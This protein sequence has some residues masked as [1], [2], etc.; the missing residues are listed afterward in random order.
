MP[1]TLP[2]AEFRRQN[3]LHDANRRELVSSGDLP[4]FGQSRST[5]APLTFDALEAVFVEYGEK[6]VRG[7]A[8][9]LDKA[10]ANASGA[11]TSSI[12]FEFNKLGQSYETQIFMSDYLKF[13]DLG[14]QGVG[15]SSKNN[16]SPFKFKFVN[17][18][19]SHVD[20]LEKWVKEKNIR[21]VVT[22]PKGLVARDLSPRSLAYVIARSSKINGLRATFFKKKTVDRLADEF[23]KA[24]IAA[25]GDDMK[26]NIIY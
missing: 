5:N 4:S 11:G 10:D 24:V 14:V 18:S 2:N 17:P 9:E 1:Y 25:A 13:V 23:K 8:E 12:R 19:K 15:A 16:S 22:V 6:F 3:R 26:V 20:A 21:A 7:F